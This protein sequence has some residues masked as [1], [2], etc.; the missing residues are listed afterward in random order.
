MKKSIMLTKE[1]PCYRPNNWGINN[2]GIRP[3]V[4]SY[5]VPGEYEVYECQDGL[6]WMYNNPKTFIFPEDIK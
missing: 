6:L 2:A 5:L 1:T 4:Y 3:D